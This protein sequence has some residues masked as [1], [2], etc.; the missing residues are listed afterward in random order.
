M[1]SEN[2]G[3]IGRVSRSSEQNA[4]CFKQTL[5]YSLTTCCRTVAVVVNQLPYEKAY[6]EL[7][8][9][10]DLCW[11]RSS[12]KSSFLYSRIASQ[13]LTLHH[14]SRFAFCAVL[15]IFCQV[16][17][18]KCKFPMGRTFQTLIYPFISL[19]IPLYPIEILRSPKISL[20]QTFSGIDLI[21]R[22]P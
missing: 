13:W 22:H 14:C 6:S 21:H 11:D 10:T 8:I 16:S 20:G 4:T 9:F 19:N 1:V 2:S 17:R 18:L 3:K 5:E 7:L 12:I 15:C